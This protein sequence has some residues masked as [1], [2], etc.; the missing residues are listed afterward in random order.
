VAVRTD[1][2]S[3]DITTSVG[4]TALAVAA[5]RAEESR[6]PEPLSV[7]PFAG[8]FLAAAN[9]KLPMLDPSVP[10]PS[11][12]LADLFARLTDYAAVRTRCFDDFFVSARTEGIEQAVILGAGL[13]T[14]AFRIAVPRHTYELDQPAV[15]EF[16]DQVLRE[17]GAT[18]VGTRTTVPVDLRNDWPQ[19]LRDSGFDPRQ[20]T[21]WIAEGLLAYLPE[22]AQR[23]L[24]DRVTDL[25]SAGSRIG[26]QLMAGA[27]RITDNPAL[28]KA[29]AEQG[30]RLDGLFYHDQQS[31]QQVNVAQLLRD[32]EWSVKTS[33]LPELAADYGR[34]II[35]ESL[36]AVPF[37]FASR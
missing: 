2:D 12:E 6:R 31:R 27:G 32:N 1:N 13:D 9:T 10:L 18:A 35:G 14:R 37:Y 19:A 25:S 15:L 4:L 28:R 33:M 24:L 36:P 5:A 7:D 8:A 3:W 29:A 20:R 30:V 26:L 23:L 22:D 34:A 17:Q 11:D 21:A 16:K